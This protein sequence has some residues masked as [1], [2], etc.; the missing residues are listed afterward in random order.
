MIKFYD[1]NTQG[2]PPT[3]EQV[4]ANPTIQN[5][6][7]LAPNDKAQLLASIPSTP[8]NIAQL[9]AEVIAAEPEMLL[10]ASEMAPYTANLGP[11]WNVLNNP[12]V[13]QA[14]TIFP[15]LLPILQ[16]LESILEQIASQQPPVNP[17]SA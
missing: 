13:T 5:V 6:K 14:L 17:P 15:T 1:E 11:P 12:L 16:K 8:A 3:I 4:K 7:A 10:I 9:L 2:G